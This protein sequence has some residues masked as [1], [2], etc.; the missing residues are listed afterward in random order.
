[1]IH[2][3]SNMQVLEIF[4][5]QPTSIHFIREIGREINL[6]PTSVKNTVD[7]LHESMLIKTKK[8]KPF[9]GYVANRENDLFLFYKR[10]YNLSTL[11]ELIQCIEELIHPQAIVLFGSYSRGED[12]ESSDIDLLV[13]S[14]IKK[15]INLEKIEKKLERKIN[16]MI[17]DNLNKLDS[18]IIN[19]IH[20]GIVLHGELNG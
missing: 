2:K 1:M 11:Y 6:A 13:L 14:K 15:D 4:F 16:L 12:I 10:A 20:N 9:D 17:I 18:G 3:C 19:K 8:S 7:K 5:K